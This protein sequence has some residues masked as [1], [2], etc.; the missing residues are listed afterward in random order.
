MNGNGNTAPLLTVAPVEAPKVPSDP[1]KK[2]KKE[3]LMNEVRALQEQLAQYE[4]AE[5][6]PKVAS[7]VLGIA[8]PV[9]SISFAGIA[10]TLIA[11]SAYIPGVILAA[12]GLAML[13][14][15]LSHVAEAI[16]LTT[17]S[18]MRSSRALAFAMEVGLCGL[19]TANVLG[20]G[21]VEHTLTYGLMA[22]IGALIAGG[23]IIAFLH[24]RK[25]AILEKAGQYCD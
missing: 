10:G 24:H 8:A 9:V 14:V 21:A 7:W 2:L 6:P 23:N 17:G 3:E 13:F 18:D 25:I 1:L 15:S 19:E 4:A 20:H 5:P 16:H 11:A 22:L 12:A